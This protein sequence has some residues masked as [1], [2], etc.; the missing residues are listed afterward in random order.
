MLSVTSQTQQDNYCY[1]LTYT[2]NLK[3]I[4]LTEAE[5]RKVVDRGQEWG[6]WRN[7]G[8][9]IQAFHYK[10]SKFWGSHAQNM[11][12]KVNTAFYT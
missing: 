7:T 2:W 6:E 8:Q 9:K 1:D 10:M 12:T 5:S 4:K 3:K 11:M